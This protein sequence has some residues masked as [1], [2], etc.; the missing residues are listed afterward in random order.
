MRSPGREYES[1]VRIRATPVDRREGGRLAREVLGA[2]AMLRQ[3]GARAGA[4]VG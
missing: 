2:I 3:S 4:G 1:S